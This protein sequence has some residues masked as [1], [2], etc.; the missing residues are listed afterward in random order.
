MSWRFLN[1]DEQEGDIAWHVN[2]IAFKGIGALQ[3]L[4]NVSESIFFFSKFILSK[5]TDN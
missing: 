2:K 5:A 4:S 1:R 3:T